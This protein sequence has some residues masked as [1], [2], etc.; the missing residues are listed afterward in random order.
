MLLNKE[1]TKKIIERII[2]GEPQSKILKEKN[3]LHNRNSIRLSAK[4]Y[5]LDFPRTRNTNIIIGDYFDNIQNDK[6]CYILGLLYADGFIIKA[7]HTNEKLGL[8][9]HKEDTQTVEWVLKELK[10][11]GKIYNIKSKNQVGFSI[12]LPYLTNRLKELGIKRCKSYITTLDIPNFIFDNKLYFFSFLRGF[13]D[14]DGSITKTTS[15]SYQRYN[16]NFSSSNLL[17]LKKIKE[18]LIKYNSFNLDSNKLGTLREDVY[19]QKRT[20]PLYQLTISN[21]LIIMWLG[22]MFYNSA[23]HSFE[24]KRKRFNSFSLDLI[25]ANTNLDNFLLTKLEAEKLFNNTRIK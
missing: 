1:E 13:F 17:L 5:N 16:I 15:F 2:K 25:N 8:V 9:L 14:G 24:R 23:V 10:P 20:I 19:S 21:S 12:T 6:Q 4:K 22:N 3:L 18:C 7:S 11:N